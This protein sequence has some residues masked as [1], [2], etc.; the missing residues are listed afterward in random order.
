MSEDNRSLN[1]F[2]QKL[3]NFKILISAMR[4]TIN[5]VERDLVIVKKNTRVMNGF[6]HDQQQFALVPSVDASRYDDQV[7]SDLNTSGVRKVR[8]NFFAFCEIDSEEGGWIVIQ[9][10][11]DGSAE[12][13][14]TYKDYQEGFGNIFGEFWMGLAKIHELTSSRLHELMIVME[15]FDGTKKFAKYSAFAISDESS[16]YTMS[17]LGKYSGDAGDSLAYHAGMKFSTYE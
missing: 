6:R 1:D 5:K 12:F 11:F 17:L 8:N 3:D 14:R 10:R 9:N 13:F 2:D 4:A 15:K 7:C 16:S